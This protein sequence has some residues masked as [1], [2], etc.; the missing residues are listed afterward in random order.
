MAYARPFHACRCAAI[1]LCLKRGV[2]HLKMSRESSASTNHYFMLSPFALFF[3]FIQNL[4]PSSDRMAVLLAEIWRY[5][6]LQEAF[7]SRALFERFGRIFRSIASN[8]IARPVYHRAGVKTLSSHIVSRSADS[9]LF[10]KTRFFALSH[11]HPRHQ[12]LHRAAAA[13][14]AG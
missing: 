14:T 10:Q 5:I 9:H 7:C 8:S 12:T 1:A 4:Y 2:P 11:P 3:A 6:Y 13:A